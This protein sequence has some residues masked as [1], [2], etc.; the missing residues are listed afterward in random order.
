MHKAQGSEYD[1]VIVPVTKQFAGLLHRNLIYT[2]IS[3][4]K[5]EVILVGDADALDM[6]LQRHPPE[7]KSM[8]VSK[9]RMLMRQTA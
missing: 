2:A 1:T 9:T 4:A 3:R 8:L 7:R 5:K 6:A